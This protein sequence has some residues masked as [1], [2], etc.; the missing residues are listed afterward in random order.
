MRFAFPNL[1]PLY[2]GFQKNEE[3]AAALLTLAHAAV[4]SEVAGTPLVVT[5]LAKTATPTQAVFVT[6]ER[7]GM[8]V[9]CRGSL[10]PRCRTL[11][12][13]VVQAA[14]AASGHDPRYKPLTPTALKDILVTVTLVERLEPIEARAI[15]TLTP[16]D[17]LVLTSG[18]RT[19]IVLPWEGKN[20]RTRL[21]WAYRK[22]G[23]ASGAACVLRRMIAQRFRG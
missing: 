21:E 13:E 8:V 22:A 17:G 11:Q 19:G 7:G 14:R 16:N 9:G 6:I 4:R 5:E 1:A 2:L 23:V 10:V 20:P 15:D 3:L 18:S 12:D